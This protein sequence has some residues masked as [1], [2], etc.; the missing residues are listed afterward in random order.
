MNE[1]T[2]EDFK[3]AETPSQ[4]LRHVYLK[5]LEVTPS[6]ALREFARELDVS[7]TL[8]SL[9]FSRKRHV[10]YEQALK[11]ATKLQMDETQRKVWLEL[12]LKNLPKKG[13]GRKKL[14]DALQTG[15]GL[16]SL[17]YYSEKAGLGGLF[18][19]LALSLTQE[20]LSEAALRIEK[21]KLEMNELFSG[22]DEGPRYR[23]SIHLERVSSEESS[24]S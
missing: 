6:Y 12:V 11:F 8:I 4:L 10:S 1:L 14:L 2:H 15:Q 16:E 20:R 21:F 23:L 13:K 24:T 9:I 3:T 7:H 19:E 5:R 17:P 18:G 22:G